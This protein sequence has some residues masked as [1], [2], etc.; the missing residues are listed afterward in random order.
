MKGLEKGSE[1]RETFKLKRVSYFVGALSPVN[2]M[3]EGGFHKE[4]P[5]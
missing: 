1:R 3:A 5:S 2:H 4:L